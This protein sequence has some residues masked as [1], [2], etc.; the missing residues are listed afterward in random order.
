MV[1]IE[2]NF[3]SNNITRKMKTFKTLKE[4]SKLLFDFLKEVNTEQYN[5]MKKFYDDSDSKKRKEFV[6]SIEEK[7]IYIYQ[8][9]F[10]NS[11]KFDDVRRIYKKFPWIEPYTC[12][13]KG[14]KIQNKLVVG[15]EYMMKLRH[16][17]LSKFS[18]RSTSIV[19][20]R[21]LPSKSLNYKKNQILYSKTPIR[22]GEM[23][24]SN[25]LLCTYPE[26]IVKLL[27]MYSFSESNR[28]YLIEQLLTRNI[29]NIEEIEVKNLY[30]NYNR[31]ILDVYLKSL[32]L[33][34][35]G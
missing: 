28:Y 3:I 4:K 5:C 10:W 6:Q 21:N 24:V 35:V 33:K 32:G 11:L 19:N 13:H 17:P 1:E 23:E 16:E 2:V 34:L 26:E 7:G 20:I 27:S 14:R 29:F 25:L 30:D 31:R 8:P 15:E 12:Y 22:L 9:P 18:A